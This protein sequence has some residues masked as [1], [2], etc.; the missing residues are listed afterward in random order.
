M[1]KDGDGGVNLTIIIID[2]NIF[3]EHPVVVYLHI[4]EQHEPFSIYFLNPALNLL[5]SQIGI[6]YHI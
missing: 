1:V 6:P 2:N 3:V 4:Y 5:L